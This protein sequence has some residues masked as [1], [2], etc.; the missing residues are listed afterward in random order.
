M[1]KVLLLTHQKSSRRWYCELIARLQ[2]EGHDVSV[3]AV[4]GAGTARHALDRV[5]AVERRLFGPSLAHLAA[6]VATTGR[7][8]YDLIIDLAETAGGQDRPVL[9]LEVFGSGDVTGG[10]C[11]AAAARQSAE[12]VARLDGVA[13]GRARPAVSSGLRVSRILDELLVGAISLIIQVVNRFFDGTLGP[14]AERPAEQRPPSGILRAYLPFAAAAL[15]S[16]LGRKR[17]NHWQVAYRLIDGPG[18]AETGRLDGAAYTVLADDGARFYADPFVFEHDGR[19]YLFVEEFPYCTG[20]GV[21]SVSVLDEDGRFGVP[22]VVLEEP[23]HLSYPQ[24]VA[25]DGEIYMI[26]ESGSAHE[27]VLYRAARFPDRWE[28]Q[29]VLIAGRNLNDMTLLRS[30]GTYWLF[31]TER[32]GKGNPSDTMVVYHAPALEGPWTPHRLNPI[33]IDRAGAR[34]G[35]AFTRRDGRTFLPVQDCSRIYGGGLGLMELVRLD[36]TAV[37]FGPVV[38]VGSGPAWARAGTHTLNRQ[39]RLEVVDSCG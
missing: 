20:R 27:V 5:M 2:A 6:P 25:E 4:A 26:P 39:G 8:G 21:I 18:V 28:R 11:D 34:P 32:Y 9:R 10:I 38:P 1:G 19:H 23:H 31:G 14:V 17:A 16:R 36:E 7:D 35:G 22:E 15:S 13:V 29:A 37:V 12:F 30:E 3:K 33:T 24:I